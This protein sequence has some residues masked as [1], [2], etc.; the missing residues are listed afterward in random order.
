VIAALP[1]VD[2]VGRI[3]PDM[4]EIR[5]AKSEDAERVGQVYREAFVN[6]SYGKKTGLAD[7]PEKQA[8]REANAR[9]FCQEHPSWVFVALEEGE[10][11]GFAALEYWPEKRAGRVKNNGVLPEFRGRGISTALVRRVLEE[12]A[13][14]GAEVVTVFTRHEP[15]ACRVYEKVGFELVRQEGE[16]Y[17]YQMKL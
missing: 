13:C 5:K 1:G 15:S 17:S 3:V 16:E 8:K 9:T 14:L 6:S 10:I 2:C 4:F 11:V 12:L 7:N